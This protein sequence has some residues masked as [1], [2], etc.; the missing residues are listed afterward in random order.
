MIVN[1]Q[2]DLAM[3]KIASSN[4]R[5]HYHQCVHLLKLI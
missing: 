1:L 3:V 5:K 2:L 4:A